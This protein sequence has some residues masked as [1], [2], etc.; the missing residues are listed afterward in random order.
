MS[1]I[2]DR[3]AESP[4]VRA[5]REAIGE[6]SDT[7]IVGGAI[8][9]AA[10]GREVTDLDLAIG[11]DEREA[12]KAIA[13][14]AQGAVF[15]LSEE[16]ATWRVLAPGDAWNVDV[17]RLRGEGIEG[18]LALR[19]FTVNA[20]AVPLMPLEAP[21]VDPHSGRADL[22]AR[23]LRAVGERSF[24]DDPLRVLRAARI[25][26]ALELE[27]DPRTME[28]ARSEAPRA[29]GQ[30]GE[31][32]FTELRLLLTGDDP[33][34]GLRL[35]DA[36]GATESVLPEL[37]ALR[38]VEQNPYHH[39]D[40]RDH[41]IEVLSRLIALEADLEGLVADDAEEVRRLLAE[42]L[43]DQLSRG[44]ALRFAALFHDLGKPETRSKGEGGRVLF[45]GHDRAG[46]RI[47]RELCRRL[48]AS[49]RLA[50]YLANLTL[51]HLRLGFLVHERPL[52][53]RHVYEYLRATDPDSVDVTL[54]TVADRLATQG[55][56]TRQE[57]IDAHL[58]LAREMIGEA[59]V[60]RR[61]GPPRSPIRG[62][63]LASVLDIDPGPELGRLLGEIEAAVFAGEVSGRDD[64]IALARKLI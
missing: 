11:R 23:V 64:A 39:L 35:L 45:I 52:S 54:L 43:A 15:Q 9:D 10:L 33:V 49:R 16:F 31:R 38:G 40:V 50:D 7:W 63:D 60:W 18:D 29:G 28:L 4:A 6:A 59:I 56:R 37:D 12:A 62:D 8:R 36:L 24:A 13:G 5:C 44:G 48:R 57:A 3:L 1:A 58:D 2:A 42:P 22:D 27:I 26:A 46:A 30:A 19:D 55:E 14:V 53:R 17:A 61:D 34:R 32:Q 51:N 47:V 41:T 20:I 25:A 21:L